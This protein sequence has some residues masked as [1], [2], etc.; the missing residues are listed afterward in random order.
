MSS[1]VFRV[2]LEEDLV[3]R[4]GTRLTLTVQV[5]PATSEK[6][7]ESTSYFCSCSYSLSRCFLSGAD[8]LSQGPTPAESSSQKMEPSLLWRSL[9]FIYRWPT[10]PG[11]PSASV[12]YFPSAP[13]PPTWP[14]FPGPRHLD[15]LRQEQARRHTDYLQRAGT[16][17]GD[18]DKGVWC[19][20]P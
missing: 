8:H 2:G 12:L 4:V 15:V 5:E 1:P 16:G 17:D 6:V 10:A 9:L 19:K 11:I 20:F 18:K 14:L 3:Q 13:A 7:S